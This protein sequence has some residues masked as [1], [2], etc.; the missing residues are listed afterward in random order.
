MKRNL[1]AEIT[2]KITA[3]LQAGVIPWRK[4]WHSYGSGNM[5]RNAITQRA[6]SGCNV[7][8]LWIEQAS[9]GWESAEFL[10]YK[11]ATEAG[12][13]VKKGEKGN[14]VVFVGSVEKID[15]DGKKKRIAFLKAYT[16]F[17][18]AQC[19]GLNITAHKPAPVNPGDRDALADAF[20]K[21]TGADIRH[22]EARAYYA[23]GFDYVNLPKFE[24]FTGSEEYYSTAFHELT[25]WTGHKSRLNREFGKRF[26]D[27]AYAA[28]EL[29][30]EMGAAF[31]CA[32][33]GFDNTASSACG[34]FEN[35]AA[36]IDHWLKTL[37]G[38]ERIFVEACAK[39]SRAVE[40]M[41]G[42][43]AEAEDTLEEAA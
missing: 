14:T 20:M 23:S 42:L 38:N 24:S 40:Y 8:L 3:Q 33:F 25:H 9:H 32:E 29:V 28:E 13:N 10:T 19:E 39:A 12:G 43:T 31:I 21:A 35:S 30:A 1:H 11:Q 26:G 34:T 15:D 18:I 2:A 6:Y 27:N 22:G 36:Y 5:P 4:P 16:V 37:A 41:R 17:N 7:P